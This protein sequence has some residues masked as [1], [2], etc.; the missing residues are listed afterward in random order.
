MELRHG[1]PS[2]LGLSQHELY[3]LLAG[4]AL[5]RAKHERPENEITPLVAAQAE[6]LGDGLAAKKTYTKG[7]A[8]KPID[9]PQGWRKA[10]VLTL[11]AWVIRFGIQARRE[12]R[13]TGKWETAHRAKALLGELEP[14]RLLTGKECIGKVYVEPPPEDMTPA[15]PLAT[16]P[17]T[18][19]ANEA[20]LAEF[21]APKPEPR[22]AA[23]PSPSAT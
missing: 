21:S 9:I 17:T 1:T 12:A 19:E 18:Y 6:R 5:P 8:D 10:A 11:T 2:E 4:R 23:P 13:V 3:M 7:E 14:V 15:E 22:P 16:I 20:L